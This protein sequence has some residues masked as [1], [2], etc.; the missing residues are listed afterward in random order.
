M[1][2]VVIAVLAGLF[3]ASLSIGRAL[4]ADGVMAAVHQ[5]VDG[6]NK[7]DT[8]LFLSSGPFTETCSK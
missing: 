4:D 1:H 3:A 7:G 8:A 6:F 5:I 2:K